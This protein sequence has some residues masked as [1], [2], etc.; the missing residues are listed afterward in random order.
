M[1]DKL[2][3]VAD[4]ENPPVV[5][6]V[7]GVQFAQLSR[8]RIAHLGAFWTS[9]DTGIWPTVADSPLLATQIERF[10]D[11]PGWAAGIRLQLTQ[12]PASRL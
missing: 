1:S 2:D 9:L 10:D 12:G 7:V 5:E 8:M 4:Y 11:Q 6:T 3:L